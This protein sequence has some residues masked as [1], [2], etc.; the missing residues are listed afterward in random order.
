MTDDAR[1]NRLLRGLPAETLEQVAPS[2]SFV[3]LRRREVIFRAGDPIP[4]I[5]FPLSGLTSFVVTDVAGNSVEVAAVGREGALGLA[6]VLATAVPIADAVQLISG[7]AAS[8]STARFLEL[9]DALP[10]FHHSIDRYLGVLFIE[11]A[12]GSACH[13]LHGLR[14]RTARWLLTARDRVGSDDLPLT[15]ELLALLVGGSRSKV[16][17]AVGS[18]ERS[19][20]VTYHR[21]RL[22]IRDPD[23]LEAVACACYGVVR[24]AMRRLEAADGSDG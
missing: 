1:A 17:V 24:A 3:E 4:S 19:G 7:Q 9:F 6:A 18:L 2:L 13:R 22:A 20:I 14:A 10:A 16:T 12:Q 5:Y 8:L 23:A 21:G 15:H 11:A